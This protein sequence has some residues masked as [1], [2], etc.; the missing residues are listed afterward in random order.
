[1]SDLNSGLRLT[2]LRPA[3][4]PDCTLR[5]VSGRFDRL[6]L[7]AT[8]RRDKG[9]QPLPRQS[10]VFEP[11]DDAPAVVLVESNLPGAL[12]HLVPLD[13][14]RAGSWA[15]FGGNM[16][17]GDSRLGELIEAVFDG[18]RCVHA[19]TVHDRFER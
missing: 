2:V 4:F 3:A 6:T 10:R 5:G 9:L 13:E 12:P 17:S 19:V 1:M 16:A 18:P 15:Q 11:T 7:V 14:F 8:M